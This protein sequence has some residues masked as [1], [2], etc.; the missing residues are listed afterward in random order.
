V[1]LRESEE[2]YRTLFENAGESIFVVQGGKLVFC[3]PMTIRLIG[4]SSEELRSRPFTEF[5]QPDDRDMVIERHL[6]RLRGEETPALYTVRLVDS[7]GQARWAEINAVRINWEGQ[8]ATLNFASEITERKKAEEALRES[9]EK[10]RI[11]LEQAADAVFIHDETGRIMDVNR[12]ACQSLGYSREEMLSKSI[13]DIDPEAIQTEKHKLWAKVLTGVQ[14]SFESHQRRK[15]GSDIPVEVTLGSVR[16]TAGPV[17]IGIVRD[18]TERKR[19][20]EALKAASEEL[21]KRNKE[22]VRFTYAIS[23]DLKSPLVTI[24]TFLGF[25]EQDSRKPDRAGMDKDFDYIRNAAEKMSR[26]LD[27]LLNLS[28][29]GRSMNPSVETPLQEVVKEALGL[30]AGQIADRGVRIDLTEEPI[31]LN[32]DHSRL[33]EI[34]QNLVDNSVKFMGDEPAPRIEI[35]VEQAGREIV[36]FVRDNGIGIDPRHQSKLFTPFEKLDP[37]SKGTG[38]GLAL[39]HRIVEVHGGRIWVESSGPGKGSTF[40][41]TLAGTRPQPRKEDRR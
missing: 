22:L 32:G 15:D 10:Y 6:K 7:L 19:A 23:H 1:A 13:G 16:L 33:V 3:N 2:K 39:V 24:R 29:V 4:Y 14:V 12:K 11:V 30:V 35:G 36:L 8:P 20:E 31:L 17:I 18:I 5:V 41:F 26:L 28:R 38:I 21:Q 34:F 9:E 37:A 27:E 40:F 25:L